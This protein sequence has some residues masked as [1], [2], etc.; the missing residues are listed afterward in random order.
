M[1]EKTTL[2]QSMP[3]EGTKKGVLTVSNIDEPYG[4]GSPS[5]ASVGVS[6]SGNEN[7]PDWKVH[8]PY[9]QVDDVIAA[10]QDAKAKHG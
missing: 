6:L 10:L 3:L 8:I 2:L 5:V 7:G 9:S 1:S 4:E